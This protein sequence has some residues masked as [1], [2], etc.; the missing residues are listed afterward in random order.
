M[1]DYKSDRMID[2]KSDWLSDWLIKWKD[3]INIKLMNPL[4][5]CFIH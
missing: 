4:I 5:G 1:I 3:F 2:Y